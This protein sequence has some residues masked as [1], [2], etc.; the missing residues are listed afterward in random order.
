MKLFVYDFETT[1]FPIFDQPSEGENQPHIVE[2]AASIVDT[3]SRRVVSSLHLIAKPDGWTIP[4]E[5]AELHG[6]TTER[7][8][9]LGVPERM[10]VESLYQLWSRADAR[11]AHNRQFDDR[12]FRIGLKRFGYGDETADAFKAA[13]GE[14][15]MLLS[16]PIVKAPKANGKGFKWPTLAEAYQFFI[17]APLENAHSAHADMQACL[18]VYWSLKSRVEQAA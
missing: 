5:C 17:G 7:A 9:D 18:A 3:E 2:V 15:T 6:I 16:T 8:H 13:P 11:V 14:C 12:I 4:D 10:I 1:G